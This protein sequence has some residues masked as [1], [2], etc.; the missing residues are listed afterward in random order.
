[1]S[2]TQLSFTFHTSPT[3]IFSEISQKTEILR[4]MIYKMSYKNIF[5]RI[6]LQKLNM[7][8][9]RIYYIIYIILISFLSHF[10]F[11][12]FPIL[13]PLPELEN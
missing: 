12:A 7:C 11:A 6:P 10:H 3:K 13:F 8:K 2:S 5:F 1:M 9:K 4:N